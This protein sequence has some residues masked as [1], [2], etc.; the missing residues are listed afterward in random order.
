M[1]K[2]VG[3]RSLISDFTGEETPTNLEDFQSYNS[4]KNL[5]GG[6]YST[7][8]NR[9]PSRQ[10]NGGFINDIKSSFENLSQEKIRNAIDL[11]VKVMEVIVDADGGH[12]KYMSNGS[13]C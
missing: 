4:W 2:L 10:T 6:L 5:I 13:A 12:T 7:F 3:D 8:R 1:D 9:K 11:Q